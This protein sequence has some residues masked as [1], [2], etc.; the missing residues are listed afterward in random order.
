MDNFTRKF[1]TEWRRLGLPFAG[2]TLI[3]AVSGGADSVSLLLVLHELR[4]RKKICNRL[5][6]AHF[7]HNLRGAESDQDAEFVKSLCVKY[8]LEFASGSEKI[9]GKG[10][11]EQ[12]ARLARYKFLTETAENLQTDFVLT[13][14]TVNDQAETFL[15]NL[16]RGSGLQGLSG[17]SKDSKFKIQNSKFKIQNLETNRKS[18]IR[19]IR[20]LIGWAQRRDTENYCHFHGIEAQNDAMN[21]DLKFNRVR[22][23]KILL[24]LM[25]EFNPKIIETLARTAE[26]LRL[27]NEKNDDTLNTETLDENTYQQSQIDLKNL[28]NLS[29]ST[30]YRM[31]QKWLEFNSGNLRGLEL[32][33]I[34]AVERLIFSRKSGKIV[35]IPG[36]FRVVKADGKISFKIFQG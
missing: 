22:V 8:D 25:Q 30:L 27:E 2:Q 34:E 17:I 13:A 3:A 11:L 24:P 26:I 33:H 28:R 32:K 16:L 18:Q 19:L 12:N 23:R 10:N 29:K 7:N 1:L 6:I 21:D 15:I 36:N 31:I 35:E 4:K 14:H 9:S 20:P 5:I